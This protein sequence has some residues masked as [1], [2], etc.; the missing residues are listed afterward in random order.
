GGDDASVLLQRG[1]AHLELLDHQ[2]A[3]TDF[4]KA[5]T[6]DEA[7][8]KYRLARGLVR[9][10]EKNWDGTLE[11]ANAVL[12]LDPDSEPALNLRASVHYALGNHAEALADHERALLI[13]PDDAATLNYTAW[14]Y[15]TSP[16][17]N[18]RNG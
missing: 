14:F 1:Y 9:R 4:A 3:E 7:N 15:A 17:E 8:V 6:L 12:A 16:I 13:H 2:W 5:I 11:D 10:R 18:L